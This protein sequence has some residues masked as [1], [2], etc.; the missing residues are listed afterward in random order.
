MNE[1]MLR[2]MQAQPVTL[3]QGLPDVRR[4][5]DLLP[6]F[7][8][9]RVILVGSGDSALACQAVENLFGHTLSIP[10]LALSSLTAARYLST[11][12]TDLVVLT[13][14]SGE[15]VRTIEAARAARACGAATLAVV[16][17]PASR[18]VRACDA[19]LVMPAPI[20]RATPH[21]RDY[22]STLL[23][24]CVIGEHLSTGPWAFIEEWVA[25]TK[26]LVPRA[27]E[28]ASG[29]AV[30]ASNERVWFLGSGPDRA[31][32]AY[33]ALKF[34]ESGGSLAWSDDLEEFAH[35]SLLQAR[36]GDD[37]VMLATGRS[38]SRAAEMLP[39]LALMGMNV[40]II[41][42]QDTLRG[43]EGARQFRVPRLDV[44]P[45]TAMVTCFPVQALAYRYASARSIDVLV[46]MNGAAYGP[47]FEA[48][49][50]AWV[51]S[52]AIEVYS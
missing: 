25:I 28:W 24:L 42:D 23:A 52:G 19:G 3:A 33:G 11:T 37:V 35:G 31:T 15:S 18:L 46:P 39:G 6:K 22:T 12:A 47:T 14:V 10:T 29:V 43:V 51:R 9:D 8:V 36:P 16:A 21:T 20:S 13:S 5:V 32:A 27:I 30:K 41:T 7:V 17:D 26:T 44:A 38:R 34:W 4:Q 48:V 1:L 40:L 45:Q 50:R 2:E 49:H